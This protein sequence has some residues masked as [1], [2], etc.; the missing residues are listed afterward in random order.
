MEAGSWSEIPSL[1]GNP[2][3]LRAVN[4]ALGLEAFCEPV[5]VFEDT[6]DETGGE[7]DQA[8]LYL[9]IPELQDRFEDFDDPGKLEQDEYDGKEAASAK[10]GYTG[11]ICY[12]EASEVFDA[13]SAEV[14]RTGR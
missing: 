4:E 7:E 8:K 13:P 10:A 3:L 6:Q 14:S 12:E 2:A 9:S 5:E 11:S 1:E